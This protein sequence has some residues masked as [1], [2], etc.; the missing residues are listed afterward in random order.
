MLLTR[1]IATL[2]AAYFVRKDVRFVTVLN[3]WPRRENARLYRALSAE[4]VA[5][6]I[7]SLSS[8]EDNRIAEVIDNVLRNNKTRN[9][10][11]LQFDC[12]AA[13]AVVRAVIISG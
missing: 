13:V 4:S 8:G 9:G 2:A 10:F 1:L 12:P 5:T 11:L 6:N 7:I 3:C